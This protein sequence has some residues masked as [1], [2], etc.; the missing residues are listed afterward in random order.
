MLDLLASKKVID[1]TS[2]NA[3]G[4]G[5]KAKKGFC[6]DPSSFSC[7]DLSL[8]LAK[9]VDMKPEIVSTPLPK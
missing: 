8:E 1:D 9:N 5:R 2:G 7:I 4:I 3:T 6:F